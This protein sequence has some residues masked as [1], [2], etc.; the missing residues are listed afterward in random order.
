MDWALIVHILAEAPNFTQSHT[1]QFVLFASEKL[2]TE[3]VQ[4]LESNLAKPTPAGAKVDVRSACMLRR[5]G[6]KG[7]E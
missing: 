2:C 4:R 1:H 5:T 6:S 3:A 7:G